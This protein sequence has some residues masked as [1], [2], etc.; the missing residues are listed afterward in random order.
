MKTYL[1]GQGLGLCPARGSRRFEDRLYDRRLLG[2][3]RPEDLDRLDHRQSPEVVALQ[4]SGR[5]SLKSC[6]FP[7]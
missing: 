3:G 1:D 6:T 4:A 5:M 7:T 2:L